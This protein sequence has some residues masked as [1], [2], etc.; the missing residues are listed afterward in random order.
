MIT[1]YLIN[2]LNKNFLK[3]FKKCAGRNNQGRVCVRG[4]G[5]GNKILYR[6]IDFYRRLNKY[7]ILIKYLYDPNRTCKLGL[8]LYENSLSSLILIQRELKINDIIYSGSLFECKK[9]LNLIKKG[10]SL[11][12]FNMPLFSILSNIEFK[13]FIGGALSR[14]AGTSCMLIGKNKFNGILKLNSGWELH[15]P[16]NCISSYGI[17]SDRILNNIF[18]KKAGKNRGL[19]WKPRV[20]GVAKN[21]CDHPHGGGN[22]KKPK[23]KIPVNA[24]HTVFKWCH[25]NNKKYDNEKRRKFKVLSI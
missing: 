16:L 22:G 23:P 24:W 19:G 15:L 20:R 13:P 7:G 4:Q 17:M 21:P 6:F 2:A 9:N 18:I 1:S 10:F 25:T 11:P 12:L 3:G 14:S 5:G 8:V